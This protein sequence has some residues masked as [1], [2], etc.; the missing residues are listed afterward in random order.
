[1]GYLVAAARALF[2]NAALNLDIAVNAAEAGCATRI[3]RSCC[4]FSFAN[5]PSFG[6]GLRIAPNARLDDGQLDCI[7]ADAMSTRRLVRAAISL[8]RGTHLQLKEVHSIRAET[9]RIESDP[10]SAVYADG[11]FVC[12]T[13]VQVRISPRALRVLRPD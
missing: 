7:I 4:L 1:G 8:L 3:S 9:L 12:E 5:T 10:P 13:P 6:C 11:E 2:T